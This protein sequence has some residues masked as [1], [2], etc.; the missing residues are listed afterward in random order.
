[1]GVSVSSISRVTG[2]EVKY[3]NF[4]AGAAA[5]LPQ[6]LAIIG[7]GNA[8]K[9]FSTD[10][11]E[12]EGSAV[13]VAEKYGY[14]SPLHLAAL[15][16]FPKTGSG[17]SFPVTI[18]PVADAAGG[19]AA[20][21]SVAV[22]GTAT[23]NG[24]GVIYIGGI[25]A[26]FAVLKTETAAAVMAKVITAINGTLEMPVKAGEIADD[27]I[28]LTAKFKGSIGNLITIEWDC[29]IA[30]LTFSKVAMADGAVDGN[31]DDALAAIGG[32]WE[33]V[34]L[35][36][37]PYSNT[38][39]LDK[40]FEFGVDRWGVL[41]KKGCLVAH[42]CT[43]DYATRT[44]VTDL[45]P[46]DYINFLIESKGSRELP[47]VIAAKGLVS[48]I[49]TAADSDPAMGY[50]G[51][52]SGLHTGADAIQEV[53]SVRNQALSKGASTNLKEGSVARLND[54]IT[55]YHPE[56]EGKY[57]SRRYVV[58]LMKLMNVVYN[59]RLIMEADEMVGVPLVPDAD[60]VTNKNAVQPKTVRT[61]FINLAKNLAKK[62]IISDAEFTKKNLEVSIDSENPKRLNVVFPVKLSGNIEVSSTDVYFGFYLGGE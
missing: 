13:A 46:N 26:E 33:T 24:S 54:I 49:M 38:D 8:D 7:P 43:D 55:F 22:T 35:D 20:K 5:L 2:V 39:N 10:K 25:K 18:Y 29:D 32:V 27:A 48:D 59:V 58:D 34:I 12:C 16:L 14:G 15:Q 57:P 4:N 1:M 62:A 37:Y 61:A 6:R 11:Y 30:G 52:L 45:R 41:N 21:G 3:K 44:A 36:C 31:V 50:K 19:V 28:P 56:N 51:L 47:F 42:G 40:Y 9:T 17:A 60:V 53:Y 23:E